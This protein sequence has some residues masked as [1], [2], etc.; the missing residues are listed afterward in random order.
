LN[1]FRNETQAKLVEGSLRR[2][3][4]IA[5]LDPDLAVLPVPAPPRDHGSQDDRPSHRYCI[6]RGH[7]L[8]HSDRDFDPM[9]RLLGW[10]IA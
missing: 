3:E 8:L 5:L 1:G 4:A 7:A 6:E 9:E 2:F 10:Q